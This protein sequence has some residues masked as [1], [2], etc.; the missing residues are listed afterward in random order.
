MENEADTLQQSG[1]YLVNDVQ[2]EKMSAVSTGFS[3]TPCKVS[4]G[5]VYTCL[6]NLLKKTQ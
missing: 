4:D 5:D 2:S 3:E 1:A 6:S